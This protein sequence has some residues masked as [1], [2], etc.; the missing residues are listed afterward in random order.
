M[1]IEDLQNIKTAYYAKM[2]SMQAAVT[3]KRQALAT[4][5]SAY[6]TA[7]EQGSIDNIG[8]LLS[9]ITAAQNDLTGTQDV[10]QKYSSVPA[11]QRTQIIEAWESVY[12]DTIAPIATAKTAVDTAKEAYIQAINNYIS[13]G[14]S[15]E[16]TRKEYIELFDHADKF[17]HTKIGTKGNLIG[18]PDHLIK[19]LPGYRSEVEYGYKRL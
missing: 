12:D 10:L 17:D 3:Q 13:V 19:K 4:A 8:T 16:E 2:S 6:D 11:L 18:E 1:K 5:Q 15:V 9:A 14:E 7:V